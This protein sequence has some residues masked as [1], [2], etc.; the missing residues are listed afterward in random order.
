MFCCFSAPFTIKLFFR[1]PLISRTGNGPH[2]QSTANNI[3]SDFEGAPLFKPPVDIL[4]GRVSSEIVCGD[5]GGAPP[6]VKAFQTSTLSRGGAGRRSAR[7]DRRAGR[8]AVLN[9]LFIFNFI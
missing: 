8:V 6:V 2:R 1:I 3:N 5:L 9:Y 4:N 7:P